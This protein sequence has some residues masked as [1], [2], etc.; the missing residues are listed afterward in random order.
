MTQSLL[1]WLSA[2]FEASDAAALHE[3]VAAMATTERWTLTPPI[4]VDE[5]D[6]SSCT[7]PED[8]PIRTIGALLT[9]TLRDA[10]PATPVE[11]VQRFLDAMAEFSARR[12]VDMEIELDATHA[13][14]IRNGVIDDVAREGLIATW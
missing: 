1:T 3:L 14:R 13:G 8:E 11:E 9:V 4:F 7:Q 2:D 12:G 10:S 5:T 6:D